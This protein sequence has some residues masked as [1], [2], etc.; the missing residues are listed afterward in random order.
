MTDRPADS[1]LQPIGSQLL[2]PSALAEN[3]RPRWRAIVETL[4]I[5]G[6]FSL[7]GAWPVPD[8]NEPYYL[9][10]AKHYW[11][12]T[13]CQ[14]DLFL[15]TPDAHQTFYF[16][17]GWVTRFLSLDA[18]AWVGR[19]LTWALLAWAWRRLSWAVAPVNWLAVLSA[20]L[21]I[22]LNENAHMADEWVVGGVEAKGFAY[23][24]VLLGFERVVRGQWNWA[25]L[26]LG[27][28]SLVHVVVGGWATVAAA[29]A[30][31]TAGGGQRTSLVRMLPFLLGGLL[32]A[33]PGLY[34]GWQL[35]RGVAPSVAAEAN[36]IYVYQRLY[37]HLA[38]D[39]IQTGFPSRHMLLWGLWFLLVTITPCDA[40]GR[41]LRWLVNAGIVL[42]LAG[43]GLVLLSRWAPD[44]AA[45]LLRFYWFRL[46]DVVVP[47]GVSLVGMQCLL[48]AMR[49]RPRAGRCWLAGLIVAVGFDLA[50]QVAH[51]PLNS[52]IS[53]LSVA[54][55]RSDKNM[56]FDDWRE[57]CRWAAANTPAD[58]LFITPRMSSTFRWYAGRG[59]VA[60]WKDIPQD[61]AGI[62][63]WWRRL[64]DLY[65]VGGQ[66]PPA[67]WF[68]YLGLAGPQ[69]LGDLAHKY[70]AKYAVVQ[71]SPDVPPL[72]DGPAY[73]KVHANGSFAVY[74]FSSDHPK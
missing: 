32:L 54:I 57:V 38:A 10:K 28:A 36:Q 12:P 25:W 5:F 44:A 30:W 17:F 13:W 26:L 49:L 29:I 56:P 64:A 1:S 53:S 45:A 24:L 27:A 9:S 7:H 20:A 71:L 14:P 58:A 43:F 21:F 48:G 72:P 73:K 18:T 68:D 3:S 50:A 19:L 22:T 40:L 41:R 4:L 16:S 59:E 62:V 35:N 23:V 63:A 42:S 6:V 70:G 52:V 46:S 67:R 8:V 2:P 74:Q 33:L 51:L 61:A 66:Y 15:Q 39:R 69:R 55:P 47:L 11:N 37:H 60:T 31:L 34:F 65:S